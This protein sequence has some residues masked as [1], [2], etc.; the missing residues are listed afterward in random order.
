MR[1][2]VQLMRYAV[3]HEPAPEGLTSDIYDSFAF[4]HLV[5]LSIESHLHQKKL[6]RGISKELRASKPPKHYPITRKVFIGNYVSWRDRI[7]S[8][9]E[10]LLA[11]RNTYNRTAD[12]QD[13]DDR[14]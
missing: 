5:E 3:W 6:L 11:T 2:C 14:Y 12:S 1:V 10:D 8:I 9:A 4:R 13:F 7:R